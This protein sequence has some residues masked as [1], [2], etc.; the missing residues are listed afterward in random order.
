MWIT[1]VK[2]FPHGFYFT[3]ARGEVHYL[4]GECKI[5]SAHFLSF[6]DREGGGGVLKIVLL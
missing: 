3:L 5:N 6:E 4:R 1:S 2:V